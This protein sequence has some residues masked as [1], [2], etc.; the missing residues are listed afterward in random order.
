VFWHFCPDFNA[1]KAPQKHR[2]LDENEKMDSQTSLMNS[3][4]WQYSGMS[5]PSEPGA[6]LTW[7]WCRQELLNT[8]YFL[9]LYKWKSTGLSLPSIKIQAPHQPGEKRG[10]PANFRIQRGRI[11]EMNSWALTSIEVRAYGVLIS[12]TKWLTGLYWVKVGTFQI[13][14]SLKPPSS[15]YVR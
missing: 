15:L 4:N 14:P 7:N 12:T 8:S 10:R 6:G 5:T 11:E 3:L 1:E 9:V 2:K 13:A